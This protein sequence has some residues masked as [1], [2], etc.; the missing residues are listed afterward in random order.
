MITCLFC[1]GSAGSFRV[2]ELKVWILEP[3]AAVLNEI[4]WDKPMLTQADYSRLITNRF[5]S[6]GITPCIR[7]AHHA[8]EVTSEP[9]WTDSWG[10][11]ENNQPFL[12]KHWTFRIKL[13][14]GNSV[15]LIDISD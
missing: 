1:L 2:F 8:I 13:Y 10:V 5:K 9:D 3:G 14:L 6:L 7:E 12:T 15:E 4:Y 11:D